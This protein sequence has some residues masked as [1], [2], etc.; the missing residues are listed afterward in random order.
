MTRF[1]IFTKLPIGEDKDYTP[2]TGKKISEIPLGF[3]YGDKDELLSQCWEDGY[4]L[5]T[6]LVTDEGLPVVVVESDTGWCVQYDDT[7]VRVRVLES[8]DGSWKKFRLCDKEN[9]KTFGVLEQYVPEFGHYVHIEKDEKTTSRMRYNVDT[10]TYEFDV[11]VFIEDK[12]NIAT[13]TVEELKV[14]HDV[15]SATLIGKKQ[16]LVQSIDYLIKE[17]SQVK[18][19]ILGDGY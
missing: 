2:I 6:N 16:E 7:Q 3:V 18:G 5:K 11:G 8:D 1:T 12:S 13:D 4:F 15:G 14:A 19:S 17:L 10:K 9:N